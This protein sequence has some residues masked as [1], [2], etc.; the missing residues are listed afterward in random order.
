MWWRGNHR[1]EQRD[2]PGLLANA[3]GRTVPT[4]WNLSSVVE[5]SVAEPVSNRAPQCLGGL[6]RTS[7]R[8]VH[9]ETV[10]RA[11]PP[12]APTCFPSSGPGPPG[13]VTTCLVFALFPGRHLGPPMAVAQPH[14][15]QRPVVTVVSFDARRRPVRPNRVQ[16]STGPPGSSPA[17]TPPELLLSFCPTSGRGHCPMGAEDRFRS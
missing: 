12:P 17:P 3:I 10:D 16:V 8:R 2:R 6:H 5:T 4:N 15:A 1:L 13:P 14:L 11:P 9:V 7:P